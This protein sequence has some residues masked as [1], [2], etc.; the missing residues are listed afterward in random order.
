MVL[1]LEIK[2]ITDTSARDGKQSEK[3]ARTR[4]KRD[5]GYTGRWCHGTGRRDFSFTLITSKLF[6][7][8]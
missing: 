1:F 8:L 6:E 4:V 2:K 3:N 7:F 5:P